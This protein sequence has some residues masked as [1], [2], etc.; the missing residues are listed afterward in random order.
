MRVRVPAAVVGLVGLATAFMGVVPAGAGPS[1]DQDAF[2]KGVVD[3]SLLFNK[4]EEEPT[5]KQQQKI[6][7]YLETIQQNAPA[8]LAE[9]VGVAATAVESGNFEDPA[10][11]EAITTIDTWVA[12][13][14]GYEVVDVTAT[15]YAFDGIPETLD[16][17]VVLFRFTNEGAELHELGVARIKGDESVEEILELPEREQEDKVQFV[18]HGFAAQGQTSVAY[19]KL[20]AG[21]YGAVCFLPVG[22]TTEEAI[23]TADGA[24][25]HAEGMYAQFEA[26]K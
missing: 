22:S 3:I 21:T 18:T 20:K 2:C 8:E 17:G 9:P 12:D 16:T 14:C 4:I 13:N 23:E 6:G 11:E 1:G 5:A 15:E 7:Q 10:V 19:A 25:H 24:P 26:T